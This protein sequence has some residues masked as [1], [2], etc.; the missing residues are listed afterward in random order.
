MST[1]ETNGESRYYWREALV[2]YARPDARRSAIDVL[3][4]IV[5]Y[6]A[7]WPLLV[8]SLD[9]SYLLTL[10]LAVPASG[11]LLRTF[12]VFHDCTHG[13]Y[14]PSKRA[15]AWLGRFTGL[16]VFAAF[17]A[18]K[19]EH[20]THHGTSGDLD[21]RGDGDVTLW[22]VEEYYSK[23]RKSRIGY[24]LFRNP[25]VMFGVG[26][27]YSLILRQRFFTK[28]MRPR[29]R[30]SVTRTNVALVVV[31]GGLIYLIGWKAYLLIQ[32]PTVLLA[33]A[34]GVWLFYVQ[35]HFDDVQWERSDKWSFLDASLH[36]SSYL[37]LPKILQFFTG[38]IGLHHV[39]HLSAR[40]PNYNLQRAHDEVELFRDV[41]VVSLWDGLKAYRF[42][43]WDEGSKRLVTF[44]EARAA[45]AG[46]A[47]TAAA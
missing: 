16:M 37:K 45:W 23:P 15:N 24:R 11:F 26:P 18:W 32:A 30:K 1:P 41:P 5:A 22:T 33:G 21:K 36:G 10:A 7:M 8:A 29:I 35:H 6:L 14:L 38:N 9:V 13:S 17:S 20:A 12:I 25:F 3:T 34:T 42:K 2:P 44:R 47:A 46:S 19:E 31:V 4:S 43:L 28:D 40:I 39:H 27:I